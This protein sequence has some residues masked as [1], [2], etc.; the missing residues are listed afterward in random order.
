MHKIDTVSYAKFSE[1][2]LN[3]VG[4]EKLP[5]TTSIELTYGC[6]L[7]CVHCYNPTHKALPNELKT[8]ELKN[9]IDQLPALGC[10]EILFTGGEPLVHPDAFEIFSYAKSLGLQ[11]VIFTNATLLTP[12]KIQK[13]EEL[14]PSYISVSVY[15]HTESVYEKVTG[16]RGSFKK[17]KRSLDLLLESDLQVHYKMPVMKENM[18]EFEEIR[19]WYYSRNLPF[20]FAIDISPRVDG[21]KSPLAHR[22]SEEEAAKFRLKYEPPPACHASEVSPDRRSVSGKV[23]DCVCGKT[24]AAINPYGEMNLCT[25]LAFPSYSLKTGNVKEG[26]NVLVDFVENIK[27]NEKFECLTCPVSNGCSQGA[28]DGW[29][30]GD[31]FSECIPYFKNVA[32]KVIQKSS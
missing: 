20:N 18:Q 26:W 23:F 3:K 1:D 2:I 15:G 12:E 16:V 21:N 14:K 13:L 31:D 11:P 9:L 7:Q 28:M 32:E 17:F 27:P 30:E 29:L 4:P 22:L 6:N 25:S 19:D 10:L 8:P 24:S 5:F